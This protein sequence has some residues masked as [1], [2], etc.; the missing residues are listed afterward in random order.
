MTDFPSFTYH[1]KPLLSDL[2]NN[3]TNFDEWVTMLKTKNFGSLIFSVKNAYVYSDP[4]TSAIILCL[5]FALWVWILS[6][7]TRNFS[8]VDRLWSIL[9][10]IFTWHF[11]LHGC[12]KSSSISLPNESIFNSCNL[13]ARGVI[14]CL[15]TTIWGARL[16]YN[17]ARKGGYKWESED[18]R[19]SIVK[20]RIHWIIFEVLNI[21]FISLYQCFLLLAMTFPSY[22]VWYSAPTSSLNL[23]DLFASILFIG[24]L[25]GEIVSDNQQW[26]FQSE[27][28]KLIA[29]AN[30]NLKRTAI[31]E[32]DY[33]FGFI[34]R[35]L[36]R[37]S[38]H[39]NYFCEMGIW[40]SYYIFSIA[41]ASSKSQWILN[42][43]MIGTLSLTILFQITTHLTETISRKKYPMYELYKKNTSRLI[44]WFPGKNITKKKK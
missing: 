2:I 18:Y 31:F 14:L 17:Y 44:P 39:P 29:K 21:I 40:W 22:A 34:T 23:W 41:A 37:Y 24:F 33:S 1:V 4:L 13:N 9:P 35:G 28:Y 38:R 8:Q 15:L 42:W 27:K 20:Y 12:W 16:T 5:A 26:R 36:F 30:E 10:V 43:T 32:G 6:T 11:I 19:W 25:I 3:V 7:I